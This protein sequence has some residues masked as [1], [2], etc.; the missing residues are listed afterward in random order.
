MEDKAKEQFK[1]KFYALTILLNVIILVA[2]F[3]VIVLFLA[4]VPFKYYL[5]P[6]L[7]VLDLVMIYVFI[8]KYRETKQWLSEHQEPGLKPEAGKK[9]T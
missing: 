9:E 2:A 7:L 3:I 6:V 1:L 4:P 5:P 8:K